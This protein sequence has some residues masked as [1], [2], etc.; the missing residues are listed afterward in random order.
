MVT[1]IVISAQERRVNE[2]DWE[3]GQGIKLLLLHPEPRGE[4]I[5]QQET[6]KT[7]KQE[8]EGLR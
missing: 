8:L 6:E 4:F 1:V 2:N 7:E 5:T 3:E